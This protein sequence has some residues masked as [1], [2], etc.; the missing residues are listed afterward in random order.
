M[1]QI[2]LYLFFLIISYAGF[3]QESGL[4]EFIRKIPTA[5]GPEDLVY[6]NYEG[7]SRVLISSNNRWAKQA[8]EGAILQMNPLSGYNEAMPIHNDLKP[9]F[10]APHGIDIV[11]ENDGQIYLYVIN[12]EP[13]DSTNRH[14]VI[15]F[16][17][18]DKYLE[19]VQIFE[20]ELLI[21]PNDISARPDGSFYFTNDSKRST[22]NFGYLMEKI[23]RVRSSKIVYKNSKDEFSIVAKRLAYANGICNRND[24]LW[25]SSTQKKQLLCYQI[26]E[27]GRLEK[28]GNLARIKGMDNLHM[29]GEWIYTTA[30]PSFKKFVKH[31][32]DNPMNVSPSEVYAIHSKTGAIKML[33]SNDGNVISGVSV[34]LPIGERIFVG[35]VFDDFLVE[36]EWNQ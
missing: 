21:S 31:A 7:R 32:S 18:Y 1:K 12:H 30:H 20:D 25:I 29:Q 34:A 24:S 3:T 6:D 33:H 13:E 36:L 17:V 9:F 27:D 16:R 28:L 11:K 35:Q 26:L 2:V 5:Y 19:V 14:K 22:I 8:E 4:A 10:L 15:K 23:F